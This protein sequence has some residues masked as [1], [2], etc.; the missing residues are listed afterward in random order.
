MLAELTRTHL[1]RH[2]GA[3]TRIVLLTTNEYVTID[4]DPSPE[5]RII[6][7]PSDRPTG[8]VMGRVVDSL[9]GDEK[10]WSQHRCR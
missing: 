5:G 7:W 8:I 9:V 6:P 10:G 4:V 2:C 3:T 1:C